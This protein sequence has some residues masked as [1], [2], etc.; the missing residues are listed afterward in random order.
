MN[1][2][3]KELVYVPIKVKGADG[4]YIPDNSVLIV[5]EQGEMDKFWTDLVK[6]VEVIKFTPEEYNEHITNIIKTALNEAA[7]N[8]EIKTET[9]YAGSLGNENGELY[10]KIQFIDRESITENF[11]NVFDKFKA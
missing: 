9:Y 8:A 6:P 3:K 10:D 11:E 1:N 2:L 5:K 4:N 7:E